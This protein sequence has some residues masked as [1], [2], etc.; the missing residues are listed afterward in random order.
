[1]ALTLQPI[2][3]AEASAFIEAHHRH[4]LPPQGW[5]FG[6]A[7]NDGER[8]VGV[9]TVGRPVSRMFDNGIT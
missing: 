4:H 5:K 7:V 2:G 1:M 8:L 3:F 9:V 6:M